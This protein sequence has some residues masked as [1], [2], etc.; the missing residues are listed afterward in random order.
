MTNELTINLIYGKGLT[1]EVIASIYDSSGGYTGTVLDKVIKLMDALQVVQIEDADALSKDEMKRIMADIVLE[2]LD[3]TTI[4]YNSCKFIYGKSDK[5]M[6]KSNLEE[7]RHLL[8]PYPPDQFLHTETNDIQACEDVPVHADI[9]IKQAKD[10]YHLEV[11]VDF[12]EAV[13]FDKMSGIRGVLGKSATGLAGQMA[14]VEEGAL[15][16]LDKL[17]VKGG[18]RLEVSDLYNLRNMIRSHPQTRYYGHGLDEDF[19]IIID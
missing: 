13:R 4:G 1:S 5:E 3:K 19:V 6:R 8:I 17:L 12:D 16:S 18:E 11:Q 10:G 14:I 9:F 15:P 2:T 7:Q